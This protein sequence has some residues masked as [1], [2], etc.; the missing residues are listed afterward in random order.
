MEINID[1]GENVIFVETG[2]R[3]NDILEKNQEKIT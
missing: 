1:H 3:F 2:L